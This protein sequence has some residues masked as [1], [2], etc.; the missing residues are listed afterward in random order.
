MSERA[1]AGLWTGMETV[2]KC[3]II[4]IAYTPTPHPYTIVT[5]VLCSV[6]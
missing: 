3:F 4:T 5:H 6:S 1:C 2:E